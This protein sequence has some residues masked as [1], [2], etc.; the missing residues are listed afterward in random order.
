MMSSEFD[1]NG[2]KFNVIDNS[3]MDFHGNDKG[4]LWEEYLCPNCSVQ[5]H[6]DKNNYCHNCGLRLSFSKI[7]KHRLLKR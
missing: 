1:E 3:T 7:I 5:V 4:T 2:I 6:E